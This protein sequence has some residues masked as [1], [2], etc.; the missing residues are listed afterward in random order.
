MSEGEHR[1]DSNPLADRDPQRFLV[2]A[3]ALVVILAVAYIRSS[4]NEQLLASA[5]A[6]YASQPRYL[7]PVPYAATPVGLP[8]LSAAACGVCHTEIYAEW[9]V[10]T[11]ARAWLDDAQ[12]QEELAKTRKTPGRD[13]GWMCVNCHTPL[14]NQLERLVVG[15]EDGDRGRPIY[16]DNPNFD[17]V[18]QLEAITC[19]TC[20]VRDGV[21]LGPLGDTN[22]PHPVRKAPEL[23]ESSTCLQCHQAKA[24]FP[25]VNLACVFDTGREFAAGPYADQGYTCQRCHMPEILRPTTNLNTPPRRTRR[26]WF[27]GS[28]IPKRPEFEAEIAAVRKHYPNGLVVRWRELP[29]S[30]PPGLSTTLTIELENAEAGHLLP[31]GDPERIILVNAEVRDPSGA[32]LANLEHRLGTVF[33]WDEPVTKLEDTRLGP[34]EKRALTL[35]FTA[36]TAGPL[37]L[38]VEASKWRLSQ[39]NFDYHQLEGKAVRGRVFFTEERTLLVR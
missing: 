4:R 19:A 33:Q 5:R 17:P 13:S 16:V 11:H 38:R 23:L 22:S 10:S 26:H 14:E 2:A 20:H 7:Q 15:L 8:A 3:A 37:T 9:R 27:G 35:T 12:F 18:L 32:S 30:I 1:V 25:E 21:I 36:P 34:R 31:T 29:D 24:A 39:E 28:L 6:F